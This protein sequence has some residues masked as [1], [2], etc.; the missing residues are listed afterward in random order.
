MLLETDLIE[1]GYVHYSKSQH[2]DF[3]LF[4]TAKNNLKTVKLTVA[5]DDHLKVAI[6]T[7]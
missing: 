4:I 2:L 7:S 1:V 6:E 5:D 3:T